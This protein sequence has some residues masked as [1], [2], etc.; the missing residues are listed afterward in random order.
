MNTDIFTDPIFIAVA[1]VLLIIAIWFLVYYFKHRKEV[2]AVEEMRKKEHLWLKNTR[3][4][5]RKNV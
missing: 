1:A 2:K 5:T 4:R 3:V